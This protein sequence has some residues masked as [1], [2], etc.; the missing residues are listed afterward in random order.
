MKKSKQI[1]NSIV[2]TYRYMFFEIKNKPLIS[3]V[4]PIFDRTQ[5]LIESIESIL[6]Q[7]YSNY[8]ILLICDGSPKETLD[9]VKKYETKFNNIRAFYYSENSGNPIKGRNKGIIEAKGKYVAFQDSDDIAEPKRLEISIKYIEMYNAD[10]VY[11]GWRAIVDGTREINIKNGQ[12]FYSPDCNLDT[13]KSICVPCQSTVM[14][15]TEALREVGGVNKK[16][17]YREDHELWLRMAYHGYKFK[18]IRKILTNLRL[19]KGNLELKYKNDDDYWF[20]LMLQQYT[21][22]IDFLD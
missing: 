3:V 17:R 21:E 19:H 6:N 20:R 8:E 22:K 4:I 13:L 7:T 10:V 5:L 15:K 11:G 18:S 16:M 9:I 2:D 1:I 12:K 14:A